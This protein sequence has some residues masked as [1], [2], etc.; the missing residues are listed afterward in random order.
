LTIRR[1]ER[2]SAFLKSKKFNERYEKGIF[3]YLDKYV[4]TIRGPMD[5][6]TVFSKLTRGQQHNLS[7]GMRNLFNFFEAQGFSKDYLDVLRKNVPK[8]ETSFDIKVPLPEE[9]VRSLQVMA[10]GQIKHR[11]VYG[12]SRHADS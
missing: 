7:R 12:L 3:S 5:V 1:S 2:T 4:G 6:L 11:A 9:I 8:D 10:K